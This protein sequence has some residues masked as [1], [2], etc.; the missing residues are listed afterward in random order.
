M[1][2][3][4]S[5]AGIGLPGLLLVLFVGLKLTHN[6]DWSWWWVVSPIWISFSLLMFFVTFA[7]LLKAASE[8]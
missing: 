6:I 2:E 1:S 3:T 4:R 7:V 5:S 8:R